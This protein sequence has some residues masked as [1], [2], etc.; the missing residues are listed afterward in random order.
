MLI[1]PAIDLKDGECVRLRRGDYATAHKVAENAL[2]TAKSFEAGGARWLH[3]VDLNGAK[4]AHPVNAPLVFAAAQ[5][6]GLHVEI[7]GGIRRMETVRYYLEGG[8][9][10]VILGSAALSDPDFTAQ[11]LQ[12]YARR[13]VIGIDARE[14]MVAAEGWLETSKVNYI[15]FAKRMEQLGA[16]TIIFTDISRDGMLSGP[17]LEMLD[18]LNQAVSC[19]VVASGGIRDVRDIQA[20]RDLKLYGAICGKS[21]YS[22]TLKLEDALLAAGGQD[23]VD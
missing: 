18:T 8:V 11:A 23:D 3:M 14:G 16:Q 12:T 5:N 1:F 21:L 10:R 20:L 15:D 22:G 17:N 2:D 7:G 4:D 9:N 13:V 19:R 6:T